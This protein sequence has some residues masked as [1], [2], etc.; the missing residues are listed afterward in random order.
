MVARLFVLLSVVL[1]LL[2][3]FRWD[4]RQN[5]SLAALGGAIYFLGLGI[6]FRGDR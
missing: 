3:V 2:S 4:V 6:Y 1:V 5:E